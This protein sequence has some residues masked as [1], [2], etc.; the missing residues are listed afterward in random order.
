MRTS[1]IALALAALAG[2]TTKERSYNMSESDAASKLLAASFDKGIVP[3]S[4]SLTP[5]I[6]RNNDGKLEWQV[7]DSFDG[8]G[9]GWWCPIEVSAANDE[10]TA[11]S[12]TSKCNGIFAKNNKI[13]D[14]LIDATLTD[15][16]PKLN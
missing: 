8:H 6:V 10:K 4:S 2:C 3:G 9:D 1:F 5:R 7:L 15:R 12:I 14:E 11:I 16:A 13:L